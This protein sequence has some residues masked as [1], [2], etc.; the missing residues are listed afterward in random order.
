MCN[1]LIFCELVSIPNT[2]SHFLSRL[3]SLDKEV[4]GVDML[5]ALL[6]K[7]PLYKRANSSP[8]IQLQPT[9]PPNIHKY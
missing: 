8:P 6:V 2:I 5:L 4:F 9:H 7:L 1:S 3:S